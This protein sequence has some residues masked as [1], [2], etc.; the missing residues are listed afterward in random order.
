MTDDAL[1]ER[2]QAAQLIVRIFTA[3][4][5]SYL[6]V[7][8]LSVVTLFVI[9]GSQLARGN[10]ETTTLTLFLGSSGLITVSSYGVIHMFN[11]VMKAVFNTPEKPPAP[12]D[13]P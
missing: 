6:A 12:A 10:L 5:L 1:R 8:L 11:L 13:T 3:E 7:S 2:V 4:R 9:L